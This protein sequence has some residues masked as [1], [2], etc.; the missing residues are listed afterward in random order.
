MKEK[1]PVERIEW[2]SHEKDHIR[3]NIEA[4]NML[5]G[6]PYDVGDVAAL[7]QRCFRRLFDLEKLADAV[8]LLPIVERC[9]QPRGSRRIETAATAKTSVVRSRKGLGACLVVG[10][11]K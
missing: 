5:A 11:S 1:K 2:L 6:A 3:L 7:M 4:H 8:S 10:G 9:S